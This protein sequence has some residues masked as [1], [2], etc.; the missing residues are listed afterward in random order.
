[1]LNVALFGPPGAGKGTQSARL[2]ERYGL[3]YVST[4]EILRAEI[5]AG[6]ELGLAAR[7]IIEKGG[8]V[9][10]EIIVQI[11]EK[12]L[13]DNPGA[14]GFLFDGF[15][16]TFVQAYILEGLLLK[17]H[18][19]LM[20]LVSLEVPEA[21]CLARLL[22]RARTSG[23][24]DDTREVIEYRLRE[25]KDKTAPVLGF[26]DE[27]G[28]R[29]G[30]D[31]TGTIDDVFARVTDVLDRSLRQVQ[32]NVVLL[33]APGAGRST[34]ARA[35]ADRYNLSYV[36]TGDLL[37]D[38]LRRDTPVGRQVAALMQEGALVPDEIVIRLVEGFLR[39][40]PDKNGIIFKGFPRTLVQAYILDGLLRKIGS[41]VSCILDIRVPT[42][43]LVKRL[44]FRGSTD[45]AMPYDKAAETIVHRLEEHERFARQIAGYYEKTGRLHAVD[46]VGSRD[47][48]FE[49]LAAHVDAAFRQA[50]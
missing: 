17:L 1:M 32:L 36:S 42:L 38:E 9:S 19:S 15:P 34:Q 5:R 6:S 22:E 25:Y 16:R 46:G 47:Q 48:I 12:T 41:S 50:R 29:V 14:R 7:A 43:E 44:A 35:L 13:G 37:Q 26:Y 4:G 2:I 40:H 23:R 33:G 45:R 24:S 8:L 10:D 30:I 49:R 11:L 18:T 28:I 31:G 20:N 39:A 21:E 3:H 27:K